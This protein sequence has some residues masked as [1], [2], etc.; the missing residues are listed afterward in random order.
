[1]VGG[2]DLQDMTR[3]EAWNTIKVL[4]QGPLT[5]LIRRREAP[6]QDS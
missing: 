6:P 3:F 1:M 5:L 4:P 2:V